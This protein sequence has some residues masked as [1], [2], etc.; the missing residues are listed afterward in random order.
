MKINKIFI[1]GM[2]F[3]AFHGHY[4]EEK[5]TGNRFVVDLVLYAD[6]RKAELS[7]NLEDALNYQVAYALVR[8]VFL[9][10]KSNLVEKI[11][12]DIMDVLFNE[13]KQLRK[14]KIKIKKI[15]PPMGGKIDAVGVE[16]KRKT[17]K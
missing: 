9:H 17:K 4:P 1:E 6:T 8:E 14:A 5:S 2:E 13:F 15:N 11:A 12:S 10:T 3:F 7:D 16:I